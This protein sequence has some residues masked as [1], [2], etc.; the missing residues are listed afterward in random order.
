VIKIWGGEKTTVGII[1]EREKGKD[2]EFFW[3]VSRD[4]K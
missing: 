3:M 4:Y 2:W 1:K